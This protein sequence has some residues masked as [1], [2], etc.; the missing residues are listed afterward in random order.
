MKIKTIS[1]LIT[2]IIFISLFLCGC[3]DNDEPNKNPFHPED[4]KPEHPED[5]NNFVKI[6]GTWKS[7]SGT[8]I[9]FD[10]HGDYYESYNTNDQHLAKWDLKDGKL[11]LDYRYEIINLNYT[12][13]E[14]GKLLNIEY[15]DGKIIEYN[16][17]K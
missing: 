8:E 6:I 13:S 9:T 2:S 11:V 4:W 3:L 17:V 10:P 1:I 15:Q 14:D 5:V 16:K 12:I 7:E